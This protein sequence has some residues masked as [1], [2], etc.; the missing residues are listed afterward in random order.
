[1]LDIL[2]TEIPELEARPDAGYING[3]PALSGYLNG[4]P[5]SS[6]HMF[7]RMSDIGA[8]FWQYIWWPDIRSHTN[9]DVSVIVLKDFDWY[10]DSYSEFGL[11]PSSGAS[12]L[13]NV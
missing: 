12:P 9:F 7:K 13:K 6:G 10:P 3:Y 4:Y 1:M 2:A 11:I 5:V 8:N